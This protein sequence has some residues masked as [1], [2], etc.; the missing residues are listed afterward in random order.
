MNSILSRPHRE[1]QD[2]PI[3]RYLFSSTRSAWLWLI[4]R[5]YLG[6]E[7]F[8]HGLEKVQDPAWQT[9]NALRG[10]WERSIQVPEGGRPVVAFDWYRSFLEFLYNSNSHTWFGPL[11]SWGELLVGLGLILGAFVGVS[12]LFGAFMNWNFIMAGAASTNGLFLVLAILLV[13]AWKVAGYI[14]LDYYL[15]PKLGTPWRSATD[16]DTPTRTTGTTRANV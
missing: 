5:L 8:S 12:A 1:I 14:G 16:T 3:A 7:W 4:V 11:V 10:F 2:P 13:L 6:W 9:G 15:L